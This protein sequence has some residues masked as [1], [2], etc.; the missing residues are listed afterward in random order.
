MKTI[1]VILNWNGKEILQ[2]CLISIK[3]NVSLKDYK[4]IVVDNGSSDGSQNM[5]KRKFKWI[6]LIEN[7]KNEGFSGG[8]NIGVRYGIKKYNPEYVYFLNNDTKI[9]KGWLEEAIKCIESN[10][11]I[12]IVGSKQLTFD[13]KPGLSA[14]WITMFKTQYYFGEK[15]KEVN[16]VSGAG[17]LIKT[18]VIE[19]VGKA[20]D[21]IYNPV[22]YEETDLEKRVLNAGFK[23]IHCP[24]SVFLHMGGGDVTKN[25]LPNK[26]IFYRNRLIYFLRYYSFFYFFPRII[27]DFIRGIKNNNLESVIRGYKEGYKIFKNKSKI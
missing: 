12:G 1:I 19:R 15:D 9:K 17:F 24:K 10:S 7:N 25:K 3:K 22:Y 18:K 20:F 11:K 4:V 21:E 27:G 26:D 16:W 13:N 6:D 5:I 14:G 23:I 2:D 8:N